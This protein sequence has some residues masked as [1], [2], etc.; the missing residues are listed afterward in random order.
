MNTWVFSPWGLEGGVENLP[1]ENSS[2]CGDHSDNHSGKE[3]DSS[4]EPGRGGEEDFFC[5]TMRATK[6]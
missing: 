5:Q 2:H 1:N 6:A 4:H 3:S